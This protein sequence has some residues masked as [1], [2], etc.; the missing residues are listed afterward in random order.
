MKD[1]REQ[2][3]EVERRMGDYVKKRDA[4]WARV[5][6]AYQGVLAYR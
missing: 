1:L 4:L 5:E 3:T 2:V 6:A